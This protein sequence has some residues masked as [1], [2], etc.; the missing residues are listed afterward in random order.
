MSLW[1]LDTSAALKVLLDEPESAALIRALDGRPDG[2][3][4]IGTLLLET[5]L[6][7]AAQRRAALS[8]ALVSEFLG[9]ISLYA[10]D[11]AMFREAGLLQGEHLRSLDALH[12]V[13]AIR[14]GVDAVVTYDHRLRDA[15]E[16][17]GFSVVAP[18]G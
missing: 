16:A 14:A 8:Q 7:R 1:Y 17:L 5:E 2:V 10:V 15:A 3:R 4:L 6:R 11:D 12:L 13:G 18:R 9:A